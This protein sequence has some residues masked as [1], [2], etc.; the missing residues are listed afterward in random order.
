MPGLVREAHPAKADAIR[1][2]TLTIARPQRQGIDVTVLWR[3]SEINHA[4]ATHLCG[5]RHNVKT[6]KPPTPSA[7]KCRRTHL[8]ANR[9]GRR[10][11]ATL[12]RSV[13]NVEPVFRRREPP[14]FGPARVRRLRIQRPRVR[15]SKRTRSAA[16]SR[17]R[18]VFVRTNA[19]PRAAKKDPGR[20]RGRCCARVYADRRPAIRT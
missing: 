2:S 7:K 18:G 5:G 8:R 9:P 15:T 4:F 16:A 1:R 6:E 20:S 19:L 10:D 13:R 12:G 3:K 11:D 17:V 14:C